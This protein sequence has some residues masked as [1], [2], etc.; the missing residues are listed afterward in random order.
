MLRA[1]NE[2]LSAAGH[3]ELTLLEVAL[4]DADYPTGVTGKVLKRVLRER[5][6]DLQA[7]LAQGANRGL[8]TALPARQTT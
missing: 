5:Y 8:A 2:A 4:T 3:P 1:A 7:Y 6:S